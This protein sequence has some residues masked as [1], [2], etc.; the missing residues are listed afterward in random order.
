MQ[1]DGHRARARSATEIQASRFDRAGLFACL[2][3]FRRYVATL[4][5]DL[6]P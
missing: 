4:H 3:E 2:P 5:G 1:R 6:A